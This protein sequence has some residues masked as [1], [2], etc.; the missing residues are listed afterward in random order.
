MSATV[1]L[2]A[3]RVENGKPLADLPYVLPYEGKEVAGTTDAQGRIEVYVP[4]DV[5]D[6]TLR[7]LEDCGNLPPIECPDRFAAA[8][9][10]FLT[11]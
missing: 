6:A 11:H 7:V 4:P 10:E 8:T 1:T 2:S 9:L 5:S 3:A